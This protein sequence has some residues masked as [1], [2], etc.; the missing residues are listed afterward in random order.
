MGCLTFIEKQT[1]NRLFGIS[2]G[3]VFKFLSDKGIHNKTTTKEL[4]LESCDINIYEDDEYKGLS[5]QKCIEKIWNEKSPQTVAKLLTALSK[6]FSFQMGTDWWSDE[7]QHDYRQVQEIIARLQ[8]D[9]TID[10]PVKDDNGN[11]TILLEDI[12]TNIQCGKPEMVL[13]RIHTFATEFF[14]CICL[15][16]GISTVDNRGIEYPLQSLVGNLKNWYRDNSYFESDFC[17]VAIQNT[18][19]IFERFNAIR[20][21]QSAA[22]PNEIL[23]KAEAEYAVRIVANTLTFV[24]TVENIK[25][26]GNKSEDYKLFECDMEDVPF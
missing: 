10:L 11:L 15:K 13:D 4:L 3:F 9:K 22:H 24:D 17:V 6:Y 21:N 14:R 1:I 7:D 5:Q 16:H 12:D 2:G 25:K 23:N 20:N 26:S 8:S 18:I 19:N